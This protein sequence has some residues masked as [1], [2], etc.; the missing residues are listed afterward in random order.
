M[1]VHT[2]VADFGDDPPARHAQLGQFAVDLRQRRPADGGQREARPAEMMGG[3]ARVEHLSL[4]VPMDL[5]RPGSPRRSGTREDHDLLPGG[6]QAGGEDHSRSLE[7]FGQFGVG[8]FAR[9]AAHAAPR[10]LFT[11]AGICSGVTPTCE[12]RRGTPTRSQSFSI[13]SRN[14]SAASAGVLGLAAEQQVAQPGEIGLADLHVDADGR[15]QHQRAGHAVRHAA[16]RAQR[17]RH[18]VRHP[19]PR[20]GQRHAGKQRRVRHGLAGR[21][22]RPFSTASTIAG[23]AILSPCTAKARGIGCAFRDT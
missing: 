20:V 2:R 18:A 15:R 1:V 9:I 22:E 14:A 21:R 4:S 12:S 8:E 11:K 7:D 13:S 16:V 19:Q 10:E 23:T 3:D 17:R 6:R 5:A